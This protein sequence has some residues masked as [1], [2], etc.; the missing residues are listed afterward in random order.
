MPSR[1]GPPRHIYEVLRP[2]LIFSKI[3]GFTAFHIEGEP[4]H[5]QVKVTGIDSAALLLNF[6]ANSFCVYLNAA[7]YDGLLR[8]SSSVVMDTGLGFL[9]SFGAFVMIM[10]AIDNFLRRSYTCDII[11]K[12]FDVDRSLRRKN[13]QMDHLSV[14]FRLLS[15]ILIIMFGFLGLGVVFSIAMAFVSNFSVRLHAINAFSYAL[16]GLQFLIVNFHFVSTAQLITHRLIAIERCFRAH[17]TAE[18]WWIVQKDRWNRNKTSNID[19]ISELADDFAAL[20]RIVELVN[21]VFSNQII[22]LI[23]GVGMFSIFVIYACSYSYY[24]GKTEELHLAAILLMAW[25]F[26]IVMVGLIFSSGVS[27]TNAASGFNCILNEA[28]QSVNDEA[29][30][31]KMIH[32]SHQSLHR[33]PKLHSIFCNFTW[34]SM[35]NMIGIAM[36]YLVILM[37]FDVISD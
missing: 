16:T 27:V 10:L 1:N 13:G 32:F 36:T 37:Q 2:M 14:E 31:K 17:L 19:V 24:F 6:I 29:T 12:L 7:K 23:S 33:E 9:F 21:R 15:R 28:I 22:V 5:V 26:Y 35:F 20:V 3:F 8:T 18:S 30:K 4:P 25:L 11:A 34:Q